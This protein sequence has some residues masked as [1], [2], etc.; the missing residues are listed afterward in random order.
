M[1]A[2]SRCYLLLTAADLRVLAGTRRVAGPLSMY[3]TTS[4]SGSG[5]PVAGDEEA[6]HAALQMAARAALAHGGP[7]ILAAA[8]LDPD[9]L[10]DLRP[11]GTGSEARLLT[12]LSLSR[13][14]ALHVG[15]DALG[16]PAPVTAGDTDIELSWYDTTEVEHLAGL[17]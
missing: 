13:V 14:A 17:L 6:E 3:T 15:E 1:A 16:R 12:D 7:V 11:E 9:T 5:G 10:A 2:S 4:S 8:D